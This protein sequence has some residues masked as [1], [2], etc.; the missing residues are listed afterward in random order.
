MVPLSGHHPQ[1][2]TED[3]RSSV[4]EAQYA[5]STR[6]TRAHKRVRTNENATFFSVQR[7]MALARSFVK[8]ERQLHCAN[9]RA[10]TKTQ[11]ASQ[12]PE[13]TKALLCQ[14]TH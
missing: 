10:Q 3:T 11:S 2:F 8:P 13:L 7:Q 1:V 6:K 4:P 14:Q 5:G 12:Q 9:H